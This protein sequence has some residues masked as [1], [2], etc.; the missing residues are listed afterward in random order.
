M[1]RAI[2]HG[3]ARDKATVGTAKTSITPGIRKQRNKDKEEGKSYLFFTHLYQTHE[4]PA[5]LELT[6]GGCHI[7]LRSKTQCIPA[8][9]IPAFFLHTSPISTTVSKTCAICHV[10]T[11]DTLESWVTL[12][13]IT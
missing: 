13:S 1:A 6:T 9:E 7:A 3:A 2:V 10:T 5:Y 12:A 8:S 11:I 4:L